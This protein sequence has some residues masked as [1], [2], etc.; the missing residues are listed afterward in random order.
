VVLLQAGT[1]QSEVLDISGFAGRDQL[2]VE[3]RA[4]NDNPSSSSIRNAV[5][6]LGDGSRVGSGEYNSTYVGVP[7]PSTT[8]TTGN[9]QLEIR[10]GDQFFQSQQFGPPIYTKSFDTND[11]LAEQVSLIAPAGNLL[12][13]G[14]KFSISDGGRLITFEF[15][16][17][18]SAGLGNVPVRFAASDPAYV[19]AR[20]IRDAINSSGVQS[21]FQGSI[22][23][24]SSSGEQS[25]TTGKDTK[26]NLHGTAYFKSIL[27]ANPAGAVEL[28]V[29]EG[30]SDSN[31]RRQQ[32]E[33]IVQ[34]SYIRKP[35]DYGV[36]S[37]PA[38]RLPDPRDTLDAFTRSQMQEI[39]NLVGT[40]AVR[41]LSVLN[42]GV[43]G[44]MLP[45]L[46]VQNNVLE[47]GGLGGVR[48][49]GELP[50]WMLSPNFIP[51]FEPGTDPNGFLWDGN[52]FVN[53]DGG[54]NPISHFGSYIDDGD[55]LVVDSD[56]TRV[57]MEFEDLAG[58]NTG[59]PVAGSGQVEGNGYRS[60][61][62]VAW[63][64]DTGGSF[65]QRLTCTN[66]TA[67]ATTAY[68]TAH[69]LRDSILSSILVTNGTT[70]VVTATV[71]ASLLGP[72]PRAPDSDLFGYP[73]YFNR[74]AIYLEGVSNLQ[75][76]DYNGANQYTIDGRNSL[77]N[78]NP[79]DIR[80]L[81]LGEA[82]QPQALIV[83]NTIIGTDGRASFNGESALNETNDTIA[84]AVQ[85]WQGT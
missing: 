25:G 66:C 77:G 72:D 23:A 45:G 68:E 5:I 84:D 27:A 54:T 15:T 75:W 71:A 76:Q 14:D 12:T 52:P 40:Q 10:L 81:D 78:S 62:S 41:N 85:T 49:Q 46:V 28:V 6:Q 55:I 58:G 1:P 60:D 33:V 24:A 18:G 82:P 2:R 21:Q 4:R 56:R 8:V 39:P 43:Q 34:N 22:R 7:V 29:Y 48:V 19:V 3:F 31:A 65:Y 61:S 57:R 51:Y 35:R 83:N 20:A 30:K 63:Y 16:T 53:S 38:A 79:F 13:A 17:S 50:I 69:A 44:G 32:G 26:I 67:F 37:E 42:N 70:Q 59:N 36:W 74:P 64:R 73:Q 47:E 9:Y 11:R 80:Q